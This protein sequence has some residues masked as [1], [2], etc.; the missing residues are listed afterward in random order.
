MVKDGS[1]R[2]RL[3]SLWLLCFCLCTTLVSLAADVVTY[4]NDIARTGQNLS[5]IALTPSNVG[6]SSFGK[7]FTLPV[8]GVINAQP[9][10]LSGVSIPGRGTYNVVY[11]VTENDSVYAFDAN[12]RSLLWQVSVLGSDETPADT[13]NCNQ[14]RPQIGITSTPVIDRSS[15][16]NGTIYV[17]A[18][19]KDDSGYYQRI[20]ALDVTNG[21]E[22]FGGP[23]T[24]R[25]KYPG[26]GDNS[27]G[28]YV[29]FDPRQYAE[30][31]ALLLL[32]HVIYTAWTS[33]CD[34]RPY[35]GWV[36]GYDRTRW[37]KPAC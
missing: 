10:Y 2:L 4:H 29:V 12:S 8:D 24:I 23:T 33:H 14:I 30:R 31:Q 27:H 5:E 32:N 35:T 18:M 6:P 19:S 7:L 1:R 16:P 22:E 25:A 11:A 9:L 28:G 21:Q 26:H 17:V 37:S 36:I 15:G 13:H 20:H 34:Y 3:S